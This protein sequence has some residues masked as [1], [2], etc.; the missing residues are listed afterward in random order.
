MLVVCEEQKIDFLFIAG[1]LFHRQPLKRELKELNCLFGRLTVTQV[2]LIAGNHDYLKKDSYYLTF[3]W[4]DH[5][6]MLLTPEISCVEFPR[7]S[8]AVYGLSYYS[9]EITEERYAKA[10]PKQRQGYEI[11]IA[12]G[13]DAKH[14]PMKKE[15]LLGLGYDYIALGHIHKPQQ[16]CPGKIAYAGAL[17]PIDKNDTGMH[18]YIAGEITAKG[19]RTTFVPMAKREYVH[20]EIPVSE[21]STGYGLQEEL[22]KRIEERGIE[23]IYKLTLTGKRDPDIVFD[24][25]GLDPFGNVI[26]ILDN[27][28]PAYRFEKIREQNRDNILGWFIESFGRS[29]EDSIAYQ[30]LCEGVQALIETRRR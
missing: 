19:C 9:K 28:T 26:E 15:D 29:E 23:N 11:L 2:I 6:H 25:A 18:G 27:T 1:D 8:L 22:K 16:V 7:H 3:K 30:A 13:G 12:H 21:R 17:E 20:M 5:V 24:P 10:F 4:D 14:I